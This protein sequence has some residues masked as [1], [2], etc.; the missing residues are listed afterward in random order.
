[1]ECNQ[2]PRHCGVKRDAGERGFCGTDAVFS[3]ARV[4]PHPWEEPPIS[5]QRGSGTVFF[6]GCNLRCVYCQNRDISRGESDIKLS[7]KALEEK[8]LALQDSGVHNINLVTPSHYT[9]QLIPLLKRIKPLITVPV[10]WN[11]S[12]YESVSSLR[13]LEGLVDVYLPD[14][15]YYSEELSAAYSSAPD[16][17][18]VAA[19]AL[20]EMLR[21][22]PQAEIGE[23]GLMKRGVIVRHLLL[24]SCRKDSINLLR[25]LKERF[26]SDAFL[27][28]LMRQY[29]P[30]FAMDTPFQNLHRRVTSFEYQSVLEVAEELGFGG[31]SQDSDSATA[32]F[33]PDFESLN[34]S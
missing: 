22:Q 17:F 2:C 10:V 8:I 19:L 15:K 1:M 31:F 21:Q 26:G 23:N 30:D 27:L 6:A 33:T 14:V 5:G 24:P 18:E 3:V 13:K 34:K 9:E 12:G 7:S 11:S 29:T 32:A 25:A 20:G 28:S 4:A 16:Y